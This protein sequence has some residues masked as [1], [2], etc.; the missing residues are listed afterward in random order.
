MRAVLNINSVPAFSVLAFDVLNSSSALPIFVSLS[1]SLGSLTSSDVSF[2]SSKMSF[3]CRY[4]GR[5]RIF[6][7]QL[8][9]VAGLH[10]SYPFYAPFWKFLTTVKSVFRSATH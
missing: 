5:G 8:N 10:S 9:F 2:H 1:G 4:I 7:F 3:S 6:K